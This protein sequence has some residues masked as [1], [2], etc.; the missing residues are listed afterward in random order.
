[1]SSPQVV[2]HRYRVIDQIGAG[3]MGAVYR[4][5]DRLTGRPVALKRVTVPETQLEFA[6][7]VA[8]PL[9]DDGDIRLALVQEFK[10]LASLRHP[11]IISV[12]DYGFDKQ[13][14]PYFTMD[15]L[16]G[17]RTIVEAGRGE[18]IATQVAYLV[19]TLQALIYLHRRGI[20]H[21]DLKPGNVLVC[22]DRVRILDFGLSVRREAARGRA[23]TVEYMSPEVLR[24]GEAGEASDLYAV[25]V[26]A[27]ELFAGRHPFDVRSRRLLTDILT[28]TPDLS[29]L[30]QEI[31]P[32]VG[33]LLAKE[34]AERYQTARQVIKALSVAVGQ[35]VP[36]ESA[37]VRE[38]FLQA[39]QFVGRDAEFTQLTSALDR[40]MAGHGSAWLVSGESG[41]GKS[42]LLDEL[43]TQ[44]LVDGATVLRGQA[45]EGGG[46]PYQ[47]W[48]DVM[49]RLALSTELSDLEAGVLSEIVP[50]IA[51]LLERDVPAA[52][53]L[54]VQAGQQRLVQTIANVLC[55]QSAPI[56]L[57]LEDLQ[58][59][60]E[61]LLPL[62]QLNRLVSEPSALSLLI[63]GSY[64]DDERPDLSL[65][66]PAMKAIKLK[67]L[68]PDNIA[69]L[70]I[71]MLGESG[72]RPQVLDLLQRETEGNVFFLVE[73][74]R[75]L[76]EESGRL[77]G[78]GLMTLPDSVFAGGIQRIIQRR[79]DRV[80]VQARPLLKLAA[81]AGRALDLAV[82]RAV[83]PGTDFEAWLATG[84]SAA[85]L[86][87]QEGRWRF[88]HDKLRDALIAG[89]TDVERPTLHRRVAEG[90]EAVHGRDPHYAAELALHWRAAGDSNKEVHYA[91]I[92]GE[93]AI[94]V[95]AFRQALTFFESALVLLAAESRDR[96]S[97]T[98]RA[99]YALFQL[100]E[101]GEA[102]LHLEE[103]LA[104]AQEHG[105]DRG[106]AE[107][108]DHLGSI[109]LDQG[110]RAT[111]R[112]WLQESLAIAREIDDR[113]RIAHVLYT[114][115]WVDYVLGAYSQAKASFTEGLALYQVL[116][117]RGGMAHTLRRLGSVVGMSNGMTE[118]K[119]FF[120][121]SLALCQELGDRSGEAWA[122]NNLGNVADYHKDYA[123]ARSRY[124]Q[125]VDI[126]R[127]TGSQFG[128][129]VSLGNL[130][131]MATAQGD[132]AAAVRYHR[133]ALQTAMEIRII[134]TALTVLTLLAKSLA[135]DGQPE[136]ALELLGLVMHHP[137]LT[138]EGEALL[139][140]ALD[141]LRTQLSPQVVEAGLKRG[142]AQRLED[143]VAEV[144]SKD[145]ERVQ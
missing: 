39:A 90:I 20:L 108:L 54:D 25:G 50:D 9:G 126:H 76:A 8:H 104:L 34:P 57:L 4:A 63:V 43:R 68:D 2:G 96:I 103:G 111:A 118:A 77:S 116:E 97:L 32:V 117:D 139:Q 107:A 124:Q 127:E 112:A 128:A 79:L 46:L 106:R 13:R 24:Q 130:G 129:I 6:S 134:P 45:V 16:A 98:I 41:V 138:S 87:V 133:Q 40:A 70:S 122:L 48:R 140:V 95:G 81:V 47:L 73:V 71:S 61:G 94:R 53:E 78:V 33:R 132:H 1:M 121:E 28:R 60:G 72:R 15:L 142:Q 35:P 137:V 102:I 30:P 18:P 115:G 143:V 123:T 86:E 42:R 75:A 136:R 82:L 113:G 17:A 89:L 99:G 11:H 80:P 62:K 49:R 67:R 93:Q 22:G 10:T 141:D 3:G 58:W 21:R 125:A 23:G 83:A 88:V 59:T 12:L 120:M 74:V 69:E 144:L 29:P 92:A 64:R 55:R 131:L 19:Q 105:D 84:A 51:A 114:L 85:V 100:G 31:V 135:R 145:G 27:Y 7:Q 65:E 36:E 5:T 37:A 56:L 101:Y 109:A 14:Q 66:L 91:R 119:G 110:D 52:P 44:A 26:L 38:S